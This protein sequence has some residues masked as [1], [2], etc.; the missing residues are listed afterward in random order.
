M[1]ENEIRTERLTLRPFRE[2]DYD[3]LYEFLSQLRDD[4]FEGYPGITY[5]NCADHMR[6]RV[7]SD[8]FF[9]VELAGTG[10]VIGN[11]YC[12][13][14]D[15]GAKEVGYI[16]NA[17]YRR[18]GYAFEA[19]SAVIEHEFGKGV[20]RIYA[21]CDPQNVSSRN[22][23]EKTGLRREAHLRKNVFFRRDENGNPV[24]KDTY[25]YAMTEDEYKRSRKQ[26]IIEPDTLCIR[27][28]EKDD[29]PMVIEFE[30]EL[31]RQEPDTFFWDP[32]DTYAG[33]LKRSFD[34]PRFNTAMSFIAVRDGKVIGRIDA[35]LISSRSDAACFGAYL[36]WICV[37]KSER[38]NKVGQELLNALRAECRER[39]VGLL[40]ALTAGNDEAQSFYKSVEGASLHD[41]GIWI[42]IA[43]ND[44]NEK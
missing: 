10:K 32:D 18:K 33:H 34:D 11:V 36:D 20:H 24:W 19:L 43:E 16:I 27:K 7:G 23:L 37:L 4:E 15:F 2:S 22:L 38:H 14:R 39:G 44:S 3:D 13:K 31:R 41:T 17:S 26:S 40:I 1:K 8:E 21:E 28:F 42:D 29:V 25:V 12:G 6:Q 35:S 30:R 9:A 5:E